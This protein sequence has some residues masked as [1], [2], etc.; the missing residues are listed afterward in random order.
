MKECIGTLDCNF[1]GLQGNIRSGI[2]ETIDLVEDSNDF[3]ILPNDNFLLTNFFTTKT[4]RVY[5]ENFVFI[6]NV[7]KI[8][9]IDI[10]PFSVET[11]KINRIYINDYGRHIIM[12]DLNFNYLGHY[13]PDKLKTAYYMLF[14]KN[15]LYICDYGDQC[16]VVLDSILNLRLKYYLDIK[17]IQIQILNNLACVVPQKE[18]NFMYFYDLDN[19]TVKYKYDK[20]PRIVVHQDKFYCLKESQIKCYDKTGL[21]TDTIFLGRVKGCNNSDTPFM[22]I[23]EDKLFIKRFESQLFVL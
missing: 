13:G 20:C 4:L 9:N 18:D 21:L 22:K 10:F 16:I 7:T 8:N 5:D 11:N 15:L 19:F 17:P 1:N 3:C 12:T 14:H 6:K 23:K 2:Y